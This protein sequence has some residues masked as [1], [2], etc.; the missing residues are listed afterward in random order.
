MTILKND[1]NLRKQWLSLLDKF[2]ESNLSINKFCEANDLKTHSFYYWRDKLNGGKVKTKNKSNQAHFVKVNPAS[3][4]KS[5][6]RLETDG[7][8]LHI[9]DDYDETLLKSLLSLVKQ[10]D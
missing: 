2:S 9:E 1:P 5:A 6:I 3:P 8:T 10:I 4:K 7:I